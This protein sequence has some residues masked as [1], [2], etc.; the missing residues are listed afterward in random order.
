MKTGFRLA[1]T[2][3]HDW[4]GLVI[5]WL[6]FAIA[7]AG[8]LSVFR[9]EI[10]NWARP[11]ASCCVTDSAAA[12]AAAVRW[13][14]THAAGSPAWYIRPADARST[15]T[16]AFWTDPKAPDGYVLKWLDATTGSPDGL[17]QTL[18]GE[19]FY[20]LHFELQ[21]PYPWGR[22]LSGSV[23]IAMLLA[24]LTGI[25]AHRRIFVD[26]FTFRPGKGQRSWL[27]AHNLLAVTALPFH[28]M[29]AFTGALTLSTLLM[30][31]GALSAFGN[32]EAALARALNPAAIDR[33]ATGKPAPLAPIRPILDEAQRRF[34]GGLVD[35]AIIH[36]GD[37]AAVITVTRAEDARVGTQAATL[38]FDGV[39]GRLLAAHDEHRPGLATY[40]LLYA[41]HM[42]HFAQP[43]VR[44]IYF[45][46]GL[47]LTAM[48]GTGLLLWTAKRARR[49]RERG[50][51]L[52]E[53]LNLGFVGGTPIAFAAFF[54]ANRLL[55][56][57]LSGRPAAE[58]H[59]VFWTWAFLI[60][61][62]I[63]REPAKAW[64][65]LATTAAVACAAIPLLDEL[66]GSWRA[67]AVHVGVDLVAFAFA[68]AYAAAA[69]LAAR[70]ATKA[71]LQSTGRRWGT[72]A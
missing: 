23:A 19:F 65:D 18:G 58:V 56:T 52:V 3:L 61:F 48:I 69:M 26:F 44:W 17:R 67:D 21:L 60:V 40:N 6:A 64:R 54:I 53:R 30:P 49:V 11:E 25:V 38:S 32:D 13:L 72:A 43:M 63:F 15:T 29:I 28:L 46:S 59:A 9:Q 12:G 8:T 45:L 50:F 24:L 70:G 1:M 2:W 7:L 57:D 36:P 37:A 66:S 62:A 55:P 31:W 4:S 51:A 68:G 71:G 41:L 42:A 33:A 27:D 5:G 39:S 20:R 47:M 14:S 35:I 16:S 34:Q 10:G 22:V